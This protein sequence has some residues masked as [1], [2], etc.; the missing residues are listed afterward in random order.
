MSSTKLTWIESLYRRSWEMELLISGFTLVL[1][2]QAY[3]NL[4]Y[5][6]SWIDFY[7]KDN[8]SGL[9]Q[10]C[11]YLTV[12]TTL[13]MLSIIF[14]LV[15]NLSFRAYWIALIGLMSRVEKTSGK[16]E[17]SQYRKLNI[18]QVKQFR[19][20]NRHID[21]VDHI[22]SQLF[23]VALLVVCLFSSVLLL[24][25]EMSGL[26]VLAKSFE[27]FQLTVHLFILL[28][29]ICSLIFLA[30]IFSDSL[31]SRQ[32]AK[33][34]Q[35]PFYYIYVVFRFLTGYFL[36]EKIVLGGKSNGLARKAAMSLIFA[37]AMIT[38][39]SYLERNSVFS[40]DESTVR[41]EQDLKAY[42]IIHLSEHIQ[43]GLIT[44]VAVDK[45][46]YQHMPIKVFIPLTAT[47]QHY[48]QETCPNLND[49]KLDNQCLNSFVNL[50]LGELT[51]APE[52]EFSVYAQSET[53][54][55][56]AYVDIPE[57]TRGKHELALKFPFLPKS[58]STNI[59]YYPK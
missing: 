28:F 23:A 37:I 58:L 55:L 29:L 32:K 53:K 11:F 39:F 46:E 22:G 41:N 4:P 14:F 54:G 16:L 42:R 33:W 6:Y 12:L 13:S 49:V 2:M 44:N 15:L 48:L 43:K 31:L 5:L 18:A 20:M 51:L 34:I 1:L 19:Q 56:I 7:I 38:V 24:T 35:V 59:W 36:Y 21:R 45:R 25:F 10:I 27:Q 3:F 50:Q 8:G 40:F 17:F 9:Y 47:L 52:W 57:L 26:I 30:E